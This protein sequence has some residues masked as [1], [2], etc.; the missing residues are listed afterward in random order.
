V[1]GVGKIQNC[2][3]NQNRG[4]FVVA[5]KVS[6]QRKIV[7]LDYDSIPDPL[8][9]LGLRSPK[10]FAVNAQHPRSSSRFLFPGFLN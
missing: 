7:R 4:F 8:P 6:S 3:A 10:L 1:V 5:H 2:I 9:K